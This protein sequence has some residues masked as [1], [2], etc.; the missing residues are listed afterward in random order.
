M[1]NNNKYTVET[2]YITRS[3]GPGN[4]VCYIRYLVISVVNKQYKTKELFNWDRRKQFVISVILLYQISLY[5][6]STVLTVAIFI[7]DFDKIRHLFFY[8]GGH[9]YDER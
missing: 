7:I 3:L 4:F 9:F 6:V 5:R 2:R 1:C 8:P